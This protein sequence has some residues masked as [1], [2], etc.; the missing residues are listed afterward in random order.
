MGGASLPT[1][2][3]LQVLCCFGSGGPC[4]WM[5]CKALSLVIVFLPRELAVT[6]WEPGSSS[7]MEGSVLLWV[8]WPYL[9]DPTPYITCPIGDP[10]LPSP[11][12][13]GLVKE[14]PEGASGPDAPSESIAGFCRVMGRWELRDALGR[15]GD[16][17][18]TGAMRHI[19]MLELL[20]PIVDPDSQLSAAPGRA[21]QQW[22]EGAVFCLC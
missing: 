21:A 8:E 13:L 11:V 10:L 6:F 4:L 20:A 22:D 3:A 12:P 5:V 17:G 15:Q 14:Q 18:P 9:S 7:T 2:S 16:M 19:A 1:R